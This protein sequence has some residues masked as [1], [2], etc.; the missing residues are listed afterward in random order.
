MKKEIEN[1]KK[2]VELNIPCYSIKTAKEILGD[3]FDFK[4]IKGY[5]AY[6]KKVRQWMLKNRINIVQNFVRSH[7]PTTNIDIG[8]TIANGTMNYC[9]NMK[10]MDLDKLN[11]WLLGYFDAS[12]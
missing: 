3:N 7:K 12:N 4:S 6:S 10:P 5:L 8:Y 2:F 11:T 9:F 1:F